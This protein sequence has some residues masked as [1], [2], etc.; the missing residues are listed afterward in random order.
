MNSQYKKRKLDCGI[1]LLSEKI[2]HVR[3]ISLGIWVKCGAR[4]ESAEDNGISHFLEHMFFKGTDNRTAREIAVDID[5][6]GGELNAFTSK[7]GT[8][9]YIRVLDEN[10]AQG[11]EL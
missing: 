8:T 6:L 1:T 3:S 11:I 9:F 4:Q 10:I 5:M 2:E 7:E